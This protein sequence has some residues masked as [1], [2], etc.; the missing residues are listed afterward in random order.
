[1]YLSKISQLDQ[2]KDQDKIFKYLVAMEENLLIWE[3]IPDHTK[4][5]L[6]MDDYPGVDLISPDF[7]KVQIGG[8][9]VSVKVMYSGVADWEKLCPWISFSNTAAKDNQCEIKLILVVT[10]NVQFEHIT[11][12]R[13]FLEIQVYDYDELWDKHTQVATK[14]AR[15]TVLIC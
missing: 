7:D 9:F 3:D 14:S 1:M 12:I 5:D 15:N 11:A 13:K 8:D 6:P 10:E 2:D 4:Y